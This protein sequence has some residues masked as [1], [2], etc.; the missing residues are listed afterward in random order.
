MRP[1]PNSRDAQRAWLDDYQAER[2]AWGI[3][4]RPT[5]L[6]IV[7]VCAMLYLFMGI[8][9]FLPYYWP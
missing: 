5:T 4:D 9:I 7:G 8:A 6:E 1:F 2:K 3:V